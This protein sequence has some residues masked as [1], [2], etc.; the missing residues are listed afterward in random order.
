MTTTTT[1]PT[2]TWQ[3]DP[4]ATTVTVSATKLGLFTIP[5]TLTVTS[6]TIEI[7]DGQQVDNVEIVVDAGSYA[8]KNN[9]RN[10]HVVNADFLDA[11]THPSITF[12]SDSVVATGDG[13]LANGTV[14]VKGRTTPLEVAI[15]GVDAGQSDGT[16][17]ATATIDRTAIGVD[18]MPSFVIGRELDLVVTAKATRSR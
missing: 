4:A 7:G 2:G 8:S 6:G 14:T 18:K 17:T 13:Y 11:D 16:F 15:T 3:L 12:R 5:A 10:E 1:L 9:K